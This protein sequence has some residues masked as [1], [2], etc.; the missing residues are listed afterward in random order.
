MNLVGLAIDIPGHE[1]SRILNFVKG[2]PLRRKHE[3][4]FDLAIFEGMFGNTH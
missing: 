4:P 3:T 2:L 1:T